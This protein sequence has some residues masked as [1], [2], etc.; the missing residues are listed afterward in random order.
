VRE[1]AA[2][3]ELPAGTCLYTLRHCFVT[4]AI[5]DGLSILDV[6]RLV[7][8]SV[9]MIEKHYGHLVHGVARERLALVVMT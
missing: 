5:Q 2:E 1:A 7:G 3:A 4:Q 9:M 6:A 8:T